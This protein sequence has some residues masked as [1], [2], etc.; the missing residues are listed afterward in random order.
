MDVVRKTDPATVTQHGLYMRD[1]SGL[2]VNAEQP[3]TEASKAVD[4]QAPSSELSGT[5]GTP[6][7]CQR[8][9]SNCAS[10]EEQVHHSRPRNSV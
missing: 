4:A 3:E 9:Q 8:L 1:L 10:K 6:P 7:S 5:L 2:S